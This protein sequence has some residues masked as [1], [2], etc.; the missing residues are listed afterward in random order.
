M[1]DG[2]IRPAALLAAALG[3]AA[4]AVL[5]RRARARPRGVDYVIVGGGEYGVGLAWELG[6]R[7]ARVVVLEAD[8]VAS[9][10]SGGPGRRGVRSNGR[11]VSQLPLMPIAQRRCRRLARAL[12]S[13]RF[14]Y[15]RAPSLL[16]LI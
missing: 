14:F 13:R 15:T 4:L 8:R 2:G 1:G 16:K 5:G 3:A 9:G 12:R 11:D 7:G 6:R 10:A